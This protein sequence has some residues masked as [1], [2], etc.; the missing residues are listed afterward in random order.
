[1]RRYRVTHRTAYRY[2]SEV[3]SSYGE[4]HLVPRE[5]PWQ[6]TRSASV[7]IDPAPDDYRERIDFFGNRCSYFAVLTP[8]TALTVTTSTVVEVGER[9]QQRLGEAFAWEDVRARLRTGLDAEVLDA[10]Q[11]VLDSPLAAVAPALRDYAAPSFGARRPLLDA[12]NELNSRIHADFAYKPGATTVST[13][14]AEVFEKKAGVCQDFAH[15][16]VA[17]LRSYGLAARYVSGYLETLPPPGEEKLVGADVSHAWFSVFVPDLG[18]M[19]LDPT[20]DMVVGDRHVTTAWGRDY[21]DVPPL[22]GVIYTEG[23]TTGLEVSVDVTP[24][25]TPA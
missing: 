9:G 23:R 15:V 21:T 1:M 22:K 20:N 14:L 3:S 11:Y 19:D 17:C 6:R 8:H 4:T 10:R 2:E 18:W 12:V 5:L 7:D 13:P 16:A 25:D 24:V